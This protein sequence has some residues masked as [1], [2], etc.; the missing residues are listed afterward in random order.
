[1][2]SAEVGPAEK[3]PADSEMEEVMDFR[4]STRQLYNNRKFAEL[5]VLAGKIRA[6]KERIGTGSWKN[7]PRRSLSSTN[8][9]ASPAMLA[10]ESSRKS[11]SSR[12]AT[13]R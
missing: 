8:T 2:D 13:I 9:A 1:M 3:A 4:N 5:E 7:F 6:G 10:A 12:S 11:Y